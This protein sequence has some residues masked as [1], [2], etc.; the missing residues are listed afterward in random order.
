MLFTPGGEPLWHVTDDHTIFALTRAPPEISL[1]RRLPGTSQ[2]V[3]GMSA[4]RADEQPS[5]GTHR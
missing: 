1:N 3:L 2:R 4:R 5:D